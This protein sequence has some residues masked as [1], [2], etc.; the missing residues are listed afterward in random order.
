MMNYLNKQKQNQL[1]TKNLSECPLHASL[2]KKPIIKRYTDRKLIRKRLFY[3]S[4]LEEP[5]I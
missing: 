2:I 5:N 4:F 3:K 1:L